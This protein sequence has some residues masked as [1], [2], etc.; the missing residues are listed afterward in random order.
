MVAIYRYKERDFNL[1]YLQHGHATIVALRGKEVR[2][3][4]P[5]R[6]QWF[7]PSSLPNVQKTKCPAITSGCK[8]C[9]ALFCTFYRDGVPAISMVSQALNL[10][11]GDQVAASSK[12]NPI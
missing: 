6:E 5:N 3:W 12:L 1:L 4:P 8:I 11:S 7:S 9:S 2:G 10:H